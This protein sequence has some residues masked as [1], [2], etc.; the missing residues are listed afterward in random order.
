MAP[1]FCLEEVNL[2]VGFVFSGNE[3]WQLEIVQR[4][5]LKS[6]FLFVEAFL[7][8]ACVVYATRL[9]YICVLLVLAECSI[10]SEVSLVVCCTEQ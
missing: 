6:C 4:S 3:L 1:K 2:L 5:V 7:F 10:V 9:L 8:N